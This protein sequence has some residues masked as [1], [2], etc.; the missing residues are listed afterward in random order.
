[1]ALSVKPQKLWAGEK[2]DRG[3]AGFGP[4]RQEQVYS[5]EQKRAGRFGWAESVG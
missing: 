5:D 1:M 3:H 2:W 4:V